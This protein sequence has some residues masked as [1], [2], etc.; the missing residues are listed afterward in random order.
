MYQKLTDIYDEVKTGFEILE[1]EMDEDILSDVVSNIKLYE[2]LY[3]SIYTK[4][5]L[6]NEYDKFNCIL[7]IH[8]G[9]GGTESQDWAEMLL[10]M[11]KRYFDRIGFSYQVLDY[12]NGEEAG[13]K[14]VILSVSGD[15]AY[16]YLKSEKGVHRLIRIS[17]FDTNG[18]RHTSFAQVTVMPEINQDIDVEI[19][20]KDIRIDTYRSGGAGGQSVNTTDSA[21]RIT[22]L[23]NNITV[24][25]QNE[26]SQIK[27][28]EQAMRLLKSKLYAL[29]IQ[30]Q[31]MHNDKLRDLSTKIGFGQ[32]IRSYVF[33]PYQLVKDH[34]TN[35]QISNASKVLDG[36]IDEFTIEYIKFIK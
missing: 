8:P 7:E 4:S 28:R 3:E 11:Y 36:H 31:E 15:Y 1:V 27:N 33:H 24:T 6:S 2:Q 34:R 10:R 17:P 12:I 29:K 23:P 25:C 21:V 9:A 20:Q 5:L 18:K 26:R 35:H 22:Y 14:Q 32:Q 16:G 19:D 30:E 13:L